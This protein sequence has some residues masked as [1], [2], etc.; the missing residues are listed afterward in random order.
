MISPCLKTFQVSFSVCVDRAH[1]LTV[2]RDVSAP[3]GQQAVVI[4]RKEVR[5][6][7]A[8]DDSGYFIEGRR[9]GE[10]RTTDVM[11]IDNR[12]EYAAPD[13]TPDVSG[14]LSQTLSMS[15]YRRQQTS[16]REVRSSRPRGVHQLPFRGNVS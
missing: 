15:D 8:C 12:P 9:I 7:G 13:R 5:K 3:S 11:R 4:A 16:A 10:L 6:H 1:W 2:S 14:E